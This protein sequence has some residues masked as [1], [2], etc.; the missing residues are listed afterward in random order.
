MISFDSSR[1]RRSRRRARS[2]SWIAR[3]RRSSGASRRRSSSRATSGIVREVP[4]TAPASARHV[5]PLGRQVPARRVRPDGARSEASPAGPLA[6]ASARG[7]GTLRDIGPDAGHSVAPDPLRQPS[8]VLVTAAVRPGRNRVVA[9]RNRRRER[10]VA[11]RAP[12]SVVGRSGH[13]ACHREIRPVRSPGRAVG[14]EQHRVHPPYQRPGQ[15]RRREARRLRR[16]LPR[17]R[18]RGRVPRRSRR[19]ARRSATSPGH[20]EVQPRSNLDA[21]KR[22]RHRRRVPVH[23]RHGRPGR[24]PV[25]RAHGASLQSLQAHAVVP[26]DEPWLLR[27]FDRIQ[28]YPV[29]AK[30]LLEMREGFTAGRCDVEVEDGTFN[31]A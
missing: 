30:E 18:A 5:P 25:R 31:L 20:H 19:D 26:A 10:P 7:T 29:D 1:G 28:F 16:E 21:R 24:L 8:I 6:H 27:F 23:L 17:A 22:G 14:A 9:R 3:S 13:S 11:N 15:R 2:K 4:E 12:P